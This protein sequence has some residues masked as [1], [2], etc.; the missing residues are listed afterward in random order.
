[1]TWEVNGTDEFAD[2]FGGLTE[3]EQDEVVVV[4]ELL[5]EHGPE[6]D[7]PYV[8]RIKGSQYHNMKELR[9]RGVAK[10]L[11]ILFL[12]DPRR[13]A[14]LLTGGDKSGQWDLWYSKAIPHAERLY[15]EY[16]S[17]LASEGLIDGTG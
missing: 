17:D 8:D 11:R 2:W 7:R 12:F 13:E 9:P 6:L 4:V 16:L 1:M 14:I 3:S 10:N 15:R 5:A